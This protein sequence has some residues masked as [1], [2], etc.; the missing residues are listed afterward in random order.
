MKELHNQQEGT[1]QQREETPQQRVGTPELRKGTPAD[2]EET[3][4][5]STVTSEQLVETRVETPLEREGSPGEREG[6][7]Q[8]IA[9]EAEDMAQASGS[10]MCGE[11]ARVS[12]HHGLRCFQPPLLIHASPCSHTCVAGVKN[13]HI[14]VILSPFDYTCIRECFS[15]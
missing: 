10:C 13:W 3:L 12:S 6:T 9:G 4:Q 8:S 14:H 7:P 5:E 15:L 11:R 1:P 2:Q